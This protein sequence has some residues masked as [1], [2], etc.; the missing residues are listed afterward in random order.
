MTTLSNFF[1]SVSKP[2]VIVS[3]IPMK[4]QEVIAD[5]LVRLNAPVYLEGVSGLRENP[6]LQHLRI[7]YL[8]DICVDAVF[9]IGGVPTHRIWRDLEEKKGQLRL[10]SFSHLPW[11]GVSWGEVIEG[12]YQ[13]LAEELFHYEKAWHV[14]DTQLKEISGK[15]FRQYP[16]SEP[17]LIGRISS[18]IPEKSLVYLGNSLP[19]REW[20][21]AATNENR[22]YEIYASR[23]MNGIDGQISTFLGMTQPYRSNWCILGDLTALYDLAAPWI[24]EQLEPREI[25]IVVINNGG[26]MIFS[27]MSERECL[28][29]KHTID[30]EHFAKFWKM[31]YFNEEGLGLKPEGVRLIEAVPCAKQT[32]QF[33]NAY[34]KLLLNNYF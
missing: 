27:R 14:E 34:D 31:N 8:K 17:A 21:L 26:G 16:K 10:L 29:N 2:L 3:T 25:T 9:R 22:K 7:T 6:R 30:F 11:P 33:W 32:N 4:D 23:G 20:D 19:I 28:Q 24:L 13:Q 12:D 15:L 1:Q 18:L 5:F